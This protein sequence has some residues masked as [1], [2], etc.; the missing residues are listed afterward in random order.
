MKN[1]IRSFLG[2]LGASQKAERP[3]PASFLPEVAETREETPAERK[4]THGE[5]SARYLSEITNHSIH[6][7]EL[8]GEQAQA[9]DIDAAI[10]T[11]RGI[12]SAL[13]TP[14]PCGR[15]RSPRQGRDKSA[16]PSRRYDAS[17]TPTIKWKRSSTSPPCRAVPPLLI[18]SHALNAALEAIEEIRDEKSLSEKAWMSVMDLAEAGDFTAAVQSARE[19]GDP[20]WRSWALQEIA[21]GQAKAGD[22][23]PL[24]TPQ[25]ASA[26]RCTAPGRIGISPW[27]RRK[28]GKS[29]PPRIPR[30]AWK[31]PKTASRRWRPSK[32]TRRKRVAQRLAPSR[33]AEIA[34]L[35]AEPVFPSIFFIPLPF[36]R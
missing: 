24:S 18:A 34:E 19:I 7:S 4:L 16:K 33:A 31:T 6:L 29:T 9:G 25:A 22:F 8:A 23:P 35:V 20:A 28:T 2:F 15:L 14:P 5:E 11:A 32:S 21:T 26:R 1:L 36:S 30:A 12:G 13:F 10:E 3:E 27:R 17:T